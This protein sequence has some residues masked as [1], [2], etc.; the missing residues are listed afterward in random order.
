M[1]YT[2][3]VRLISL[4]TW[5]GLAGIKRLLQF[6]KRYGPTTDVFCLQEVC[7]TS[8]AAHPFRNKKIVPDLLERIRR[9]LPHHTYYFTEHTPEIPGY[10]MAMFI[11]ESFDSKDF[12]TACISRHTWR[13]CDE[14]KDHTRMMQYITC[15]TRHSKLPFAVMNVHGLW[16]PSGKGDCVER[17]AQTRKIMNVADT[18]LCPTIIMGDFNLA[19][20]TAAVATFEHEGFRNLIRDYRIGDTRTKYYGKPDRHADYAFIRDDTVAVR[21]FDVLPEA[22]SDHAALRLV[23]EF[24]PSEHSSCSNYFPRRL[25]R[26]FL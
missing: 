15:R 12:G 19:S 1:H 7:N 4:N 2:N 6:F 26:R 5:G 16:H 21:S 14:D 20:D 17:V 11:H 18:F 10:G 24:S 22:V 3:D 8:A 23:C 13:N 25:R 9:L